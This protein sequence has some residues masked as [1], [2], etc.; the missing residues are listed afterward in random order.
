MFS[1]S[2]E[3]LKGS[4][5]I[6]DHHKSQVMSTELKLRAPFKF[7]AQSASQVAATVN[8]SSDAFM[9]SFKAGGNSLVDK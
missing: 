2:L 1:A 7:V 3:N 8:S 4:L 5:Q 6:S 9:D